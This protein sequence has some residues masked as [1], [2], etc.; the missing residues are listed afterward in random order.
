MIVGIGVGLDSGKKKN[1][2]YV[3]EVEARLTMEQ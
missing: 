2:E 3:D 1:H